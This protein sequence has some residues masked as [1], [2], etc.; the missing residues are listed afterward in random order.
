[1]IYFFSLLNMFS[2]TDFLCNTDVTGLL[3]LLSNNNRLSL[4][5]LSSL[6]TVSVFSCALPMAYCLIL[7]DENPNVFLLDVF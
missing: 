4:A 2:S 3:V 1:M 7:I 5:N 6:L